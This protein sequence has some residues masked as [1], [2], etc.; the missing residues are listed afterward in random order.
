[1]LICLLFYLYCQD[2]IENHDGHSEDIYWVSQGK[3]GISCISLIL[4]IP[5]VSV[6]ISKIPKTKYKIPGIVQQEPRARMMASL[7]LESKLN[8][9]NQDWLRLQQSCYCGFTS[10]L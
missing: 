8:G 3:N 6:I 2:K 10:S 4:N 9:F 7:I 5:Y 1:M